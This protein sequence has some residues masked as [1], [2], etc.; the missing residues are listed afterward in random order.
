MKREDLLK[1]PIPELPKGE[2]T[3]L[4]RSYTS[5]TKS[6]YYMRLGW[7]KIK[8]LGDLIDNMQKGGMYGLGLTPAAY[9]EILRYVLEIVQIKH[10]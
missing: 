5:L 3:I 4:K 10:D 9:V 6:S 1:C 7:K 8:T 2:F